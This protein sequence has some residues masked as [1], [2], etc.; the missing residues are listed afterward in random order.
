MK[1]GALNIVVAMLMMG[2]FVRSAEAGREP[3]WRSLIVADGLTAESER[4]ALVAAIR[5]LPRLPVRVAVIDV[6]EATPEVRATLLR[7][8][9]FITRGSP[10]VYVVRQSSLLQGAR[11]GST[12]HTLAL[13]AALWHEIAHVEGADEP[14]ARKS[15][16]SLW[17][18]F[19]RDQRVEQ[20]TALRYLSA[21][22]KRPDDQ[23][24]ALR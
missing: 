24:M 9:T 6:D 8:D 16:E 5:V 3:D 17:T 22:S 21:L 12:F 18:S 1:S 11:T 23:L 10:I 13:A 20:L 15:E 14:V 7:L 2:G 19:V 4:Q